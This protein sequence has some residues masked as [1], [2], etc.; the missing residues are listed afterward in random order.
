VLVT[1]LS[2]SGVAVEFGATRLFE[3]VTFTVTRGE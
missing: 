3:D 1:Q 2:L